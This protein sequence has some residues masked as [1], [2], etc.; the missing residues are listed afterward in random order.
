M[1]LRLA[2][3]SIAGSKTFVAVQATLLAIAFAFISVAIGIA[4]HLMFRPLPFRDP[5]DLILLVGKVSHLATPDRVLVS[6]TDFDEWTSALGD[7]P[8]AVAEVGEVLTPGTV[9]G[10]AVRQVRVAPGFLTKLD[11]VPPIGRDFTPEDEM[12]GDGLAAGVGAPVIVSAQLFEQLFGGDPESLHHVHT[13]RL[14]ERE[15]QLRPIGV[16][17]RGFVFPHRL[18]QPDLLAVLRRPRTTDPTDRRLLLV[19][20]V[21]PAQRPAATMALQISASRVAAR[22][23]FSDSTTTNWHRAP[24]D[25]VELVSLR[26]YLTHYERPVGIWLVG[27]AIAVWVIVFGIVAV[28][29]RARSLAKL[30]AAMIHIALGATRR[31]IFFRAATEGALISLIVTGLALLISWP[32]IRWLSSVIPHTSLFLSTVSLDW[33]QNVLIGLISVTTLLLISMV[34]TVYRPAFVAYP[35]R[36]AHL[37]QVPQRVPGLKTF[38]TILIA[39]VVSVVGVGAQVVARA[40][41]ASATPLGFDSGHVIAVGVNS[42]R[43]TPS[44]NLDDL[45][46]SLGHVPGIVSVGSWTGRLLEPGVSNAG[47]LMPEGWQGSISDIEIFGASRA[48]FDVMQ[49]TVLEGALPDANR[50]RS[51][52]IAVV[53]EKVAK[54]YWPIG[55]GIGRTVFPVHASR[56]QMPRTIVAVV[57]DA[58]YRQVETTP[59]GAIFVHADP[60]PATTTGELLMRTEGSADHVLA[61]IVKT[62]DNTN[63]WRVAWAATGEQLGRES[64]RLQRLR[65]GLAGSFASVGLLALGVGVLGLLLLEVQ[66]RRRE[67]ALRTCLGATVAD[68]VSLLIRPTIRPLA[69]GVCAGLG[70]ASWINQLLVGQTER[71]DEIWALIVG[72]V[73]VAVVVLT[74]AAVSALRWGRGSVAQILRS[75]M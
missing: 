5:Q 65:S 30:P 19:A 25:R 69:I 74:A 51:E 40:A 23:P 27:S 47:M 66:H 73:V 67:L 21:P 12:P 60:A 16:L 42:I 56:N 62:V 31:F 7:R 20:R 17:P 37:S 71:N 28:L 15:L 49:L 29:T 53:S 63:A 2:L 70:F 33:E 58:R 43:G 8:I 55:S 1:I 46:S 59:S 75:D 6:W 4:D 54:R 32:L 52:P 64:L 44:G 41:E 48:F 50:W 34:S 57:G 68:V 45:V 26:S 36:I 3:R 10:R 22:W 18:V 72:A 11:A 14:G 9:N 39:G 61:R 24:F 35:G 38:V 13:V